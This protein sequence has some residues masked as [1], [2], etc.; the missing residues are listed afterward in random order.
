LRRKEGNRL[1]QRRSLRHDK[2][3]DRQ[4]IRGKSAR[5]RI[6]RG[7]YDSR[8][9]CNFVKRRIQSHRQNGTKKR[10]DERRKRKEGMGMRE[11]MT[12]LFIQELCAIAV[13]WMDARMKT[14]TLLL[15]WRARE[16]TWHLQLCTLDS[17]TAAR[18]SVHGHQLAPS[19]A[20]STLSP[21]SSSTYFSLVFFFHDCLVSAFDSLFSTATCPV[22]DDSRRGRRR[23]RV[24]QSVPEFFLG[25]VFWVF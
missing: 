20:T 6:S 18:S 24:R 16:H 9:F 21:R 4:G 14:Q 22:P 7:H 5:N 11:F 2:D 8:F 15:L 3:T 19:F 17:V 10:P 23:G 25:G 1:M 12:H 13:R